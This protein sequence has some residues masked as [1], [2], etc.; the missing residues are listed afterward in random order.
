MANG[1]EA[2]VE[3]VDTRLTVGD[4]KNCFFWTDKWI[5]GQ[6]VE[7][8]APDIYQIISP[9]IRA[10]RMVAEALTN[11]AWIKDI[12]KQISM[13]DFMQI[14]N[15]WQAISEVQLCPS[16]RDS[17][18]WRWEASGIYSAKPTYKAFFSAVPNWGLAKAIWRSWVPLR[19]KFFM[20]LVVRKRIWTDD[21][22]RLAN[23]GLPHNQ[24]CCFCQSSPEN[25]QHLFIGC[26]VVNIIWR[27]ILHWA[28]L[29]DVIPL[30][31]S[32]LNELVD[33]C[34]VE[35]SW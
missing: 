4:G 3:A 8:F 16:A 10:R 27:N 29:Q 9:I 6:S 1:K 33:L 18:T 17:W 5:E 19:C 34:G 31:N 2:E 21:T 13:R 28:N 25:A 11:G 14:L 20:W 15:L 23:R 12:S 22:D 30:T 26:A 24:L 32:E 7:D 35:A